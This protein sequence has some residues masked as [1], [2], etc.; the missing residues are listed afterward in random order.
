MH[1]AWLGSKVVLEQKRE[2]TAKLDVRKTDGFRSSLA[3]LSKGPNP[4][5]N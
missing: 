4:K 3:V 1:D 2:T 5:D